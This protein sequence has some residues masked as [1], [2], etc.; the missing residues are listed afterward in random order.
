MDGSLPPCR[1]RVDSVRGNEPPP[2]AVHGERQ[3]L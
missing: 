2:L 3:G 1:P